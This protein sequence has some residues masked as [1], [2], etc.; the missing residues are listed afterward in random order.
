MSPFCEVDLAFVGGSNYHVSSMAVQPTTPKGV[1]TRADIL[2]AARQVFSEVG[3]VETRMG[4]VVE[5]AD[6]SMG[7]VYRYF[8]NKEDLFAA[9]IADLHEDLFRASR[10]SI[11]LA[12]D[13]YGAL[14]EANLGYLSLYHDNR[15]LMRA[16]IESTA[17]EPRFREIWWNMRERH[18]DRFVAVAR[19]VGITDVDG[20][21]SKT[22]AQA[23]AS[24]VEQSAYSW[25]AHHALLDQQ[26]D[27]ETAARIVT[28][29]W[30]RAFFT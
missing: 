14:Y 19:S 10:T 4:D 18:V 20:I 12:Q 27:V 13:P 29:A 26:V 30:H 25:F 3:Y 8:D 9:V 6:L 22:V 23:M 17:M 11:S 28:R 7:A 24:L 16:F 21:P 5:A 15:D 2:A 1:R